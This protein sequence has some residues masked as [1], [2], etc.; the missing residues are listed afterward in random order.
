MNLLLLF[1]RDQILKLIK[2]LLIILLIEQKPVLLIVRRVSN[3]CFHQPKSTILKGIE[4]LSQK[5]FSSKGVF[6]KYR[7]GMIWV[8]IRQIS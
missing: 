1:N 5:I 3:A 8:I 4:I 6:S 2:T 7:F